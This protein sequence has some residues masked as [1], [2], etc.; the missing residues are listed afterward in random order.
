GWVVFHREPERDQILFATQSG[1]IAV[2]R[3]DDLYAINL[4]ASRPDPCEHPEDLL[5]CLGENTSLVTVVSDHRRFVVELENEAAVREFEPNLGLLEQ[6][7]KEGVSV[8][9]PGDEVD[10]VSRYFAPAVGVPEDPVTGAAHCTLVPYWSRKL[11]KTTLHARQLSQRGGDVYCEHM[12]DRVML[13][14]NVVPY[15]EGVIRV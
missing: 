12:D 6:L 2:E 5:A 8:T 3:S 11:E 7:P 9:A 1:Q 14:G 13:T 10:F 4:P 15:L